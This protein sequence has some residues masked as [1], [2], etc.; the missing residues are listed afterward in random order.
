MKT[1]RILNTLSAV[2]S[3]FAVT[4]CQMDITSARP[5]L[6]YTVIEP[7]EPFTTKPPVLPEKQDNY[8]VGYGYGYGYARPAVRVLTGNGYVPMDP[9][10]GMPGMPGVVV[11]GGNSGSN[12]TVINY[13]SSGR[14]IGISSNYSNGSSSGTNAI[15]NRP[16]AGTELGN[17]LDG[18]TGYI[19]WYGAGPSWYASAQQSAALIQATGSSN[20]SGSVKDKI[21]EQYKT[22][23]G[24][25]KYKNGKY[26]FFVFEPKTR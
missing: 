26:P 17:T 20:T 5:D 14:T 18:T 23:E 7:T 9:M 11:N 10:P 12:G 13:G 25:I 22:P 16:T 19:K 8:Y 21:E 24:T 2:A 6:S 15:S 4:S 3:L 1:S